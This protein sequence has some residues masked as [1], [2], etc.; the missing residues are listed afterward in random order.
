M[1]IVRRK[2]TRSTPTT[3]WDLSS[4]S[5]FGELFG[6]VDQL[7]NDL[8]S[9]TYRTGG[10]QGYPV[11]LYETGDALVL[12][13][14]VPGIDVGELDISIEGRQLSVQGVISQP[15]FDEG[16]DRRYWL[17]TIPR[18]EFRRTVTLPTTVEVDNAEATVQNG[19]LKLHMPKVNEH[20]ARKI[21]VRAGS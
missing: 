10:V 16:N 2:G 9:R 19:V 1:T 21:E 18:G 14:A 3:G 11:D 5:P 6:D 4:F 20:R 15:E 7:F 13:M 17:Q 12:E 8:G